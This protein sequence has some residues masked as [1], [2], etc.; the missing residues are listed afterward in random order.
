[1]LLDP[2]EEEFDAPAALVEFGDRERR[3]L[4]V[5]G[6]ERHLLVCGSSRI[7][8]RSGGQA[9]G[10]QVETTPPRPMAARRTGADGADGWRV[11]DLPP[12]YVGNRPID[13]LARG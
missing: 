5:V 11:G 10:A 2:L 3:Q 4:E 7:C 12:D 9:T 13:R 1:V 6:E 8:V